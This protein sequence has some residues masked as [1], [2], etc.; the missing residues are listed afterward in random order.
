MLNILSSAQD[1]GI[2]LG[3]S[4]NQNST[5]AFYDLGDPTGINMEVNIWG[6]VRF[7]GKY[8]LPYTTTFLD[9]MS[10]AGGPLE[11][12]N[13]EDIRILRQ[14][15]DS[16][17]NKT[18]LIKLNYNDLL[19]ENKIESNKKMNPQLKSGDVVLIR[20]ERRYST[21]EDIS[22]YLPIFTTFI[23]IV[24]LIITLRK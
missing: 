10:F 24:T 22:F 11:N 13:L 21:R 1:N 12:S 20:E 18:E 17:N 19:W 14:G 8:K 2:L 7:P 16:L 5:A 3:K 6:F 15:Q 9:L 4:T 23:T